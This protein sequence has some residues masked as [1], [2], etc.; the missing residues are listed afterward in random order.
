MSAAYKITARAIDTARLL[1]QQAKDKKVE[2][3]ITHNLKEP[4]YGG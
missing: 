2:I 1:K 3:V 4:S